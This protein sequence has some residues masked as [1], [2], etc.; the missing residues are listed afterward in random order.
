MEGS[1]D[2]SYNGVLIVHGSTQAG[3]KARPHTWLVCM[4]QG[5]G[6]KQRLRGGAPILRLLLSLLLLLLMF[7]IFFSLF[8][9]IYLIYIF[10]S[11]FSPFFSSFFHSSFFLFFYSKVEVTS[12]FFFLTK[13]TFGVYG[14][15]W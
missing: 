10:F 12:F 13:I 8:F 4:D 11:I 3:T 7:C 9:H 5:P 6:G 14:T 15:L 2:D 1:F